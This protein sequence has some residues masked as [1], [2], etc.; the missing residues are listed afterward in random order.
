VWWGL[1]YSGAEIESTVQDLINNQSVNQVISNIFMADNSGSTILSLLCGVDGLCGAIGDVY[2]GI[3]EQWN[4]LYSPEE[5]KS[6]VFSPVS[7]T[8]SMSIFNTIQA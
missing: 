1:W 2:A 4:I 3:N 5:T 6:R 7:T 8:I